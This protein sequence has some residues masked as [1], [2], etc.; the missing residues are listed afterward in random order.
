MRKVTLRIEGLVLDYGYGETGADLEADCIVDN[1][2]VE[3]TAC[4][5]WYLDNDGGVKKEDTAYEPNEK[6][7]EYIK[8]KA[9]EL[10]DWRPVD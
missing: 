2:R 3:I 8:F 5:V 1:G 10:V 7:E 9:L 6:W 4:T